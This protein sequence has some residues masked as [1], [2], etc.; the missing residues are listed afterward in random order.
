LNVPAQ[1]VVVSGAIGVRPEKKADGTTGVSYQVHE[2]FPA[3]AL[4]ARLRAALT[5]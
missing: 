4:L 2:A 5:L 3:D 1:I